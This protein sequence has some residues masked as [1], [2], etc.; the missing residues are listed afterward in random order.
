MGTRYHTPVRMAIRQS[1]SSLVQ[2]GMP[3]KIRVFP[4]SAASGMPRD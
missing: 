4:G 3:K 1:P 2:V